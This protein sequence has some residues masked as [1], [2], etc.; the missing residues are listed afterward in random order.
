MK[1]ALLT[2][3]LLFSFLAAFAQP[4]SWNITGIG[5]GGAFFAPS[6]NPANN[7]EYYVASDM[8][9]L[10]HTTD[11]GQSY[12]QVHFLQFQGGHSSTVRFTSTA[13][14]LYGIS[15][16]NDIGTPVKSTDNG[17]TW[18]T[19]AGNPD[20]NS[21]VYTIDV[22]YNNPLRVVI[23]FYGE[24]YFSN[25][26]GNTFT[27]FHTCLNNGAGNVVGGVFFDGNNIYVGTNDGVLVSTNAG[28]SWSTASISGLGNG[29]QIFSFAAGKVGNVTRFFCLTSLA[30]N[31]YVGVVGSDYWGFMAGVYSCDYGS[32]NWVP[33]M[34]GLAV[35]TDF[36]MF[37][38]M[39]GN[40]INTVYLGGS[41]SN[42][43]PSI[44][45]TTNA[46]GL[47]SETFIT[48][49]NQ[50]IITGWSGTGGDRGWGF[51]EC[52]FGM[53]VAPNNSGTVIFG[54]FGFVH[55]TSNGGTTWQQAYVNTANQ[56]PAN[57]NTPPNQ[58]YN[59]IGLE[60]TSCWQVHFINSSNIFSCYTDIRGIRSTDAGN[61]WSFNYTGS[62]ANTMYR[63]AQGGNGTL[64]VA[65][66]NIHDMYE[67]TR[68]QDAILDGTDANG[69][70]LYSN[71]NGQTWT[72][73][74]NFNHPVVWIALDPNNPNRAY[75]SV[76]HYNGGN[77]TGGIYICNDLQN[78][79]SSTWTLLADPPRTEKHPFSLVVLNDGKLVATFSGRRNSSGT[80]T[81]S[82]GCYIYDPAGNSWTDVSDPGMDYYTKDI[83]VDPND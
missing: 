54:D 40:D 62:T 76:I 23:S 82:S 43:Y 5:G 34:N 74:H 58:S 31:V 14:L 18:N 45:K 21:D 77:G 70:I 57:A 13:N 12:S 19:L 73:L 56:H 65:T 36:P 69:K 46:G 2:S 35:G 6:I 44:K 32:G 8:S 30:G 29:E 81:A 24:I 9:A 39:A 60:N 63:M 20:P 16:I 27:L 25:D 79:S 1:K 37:V 28:T 51:G 42:S 64:Y 83:V 78:L 71:N 10:Y 48:A 75:A 59:S 4:A 38:G 61:S 15:Y 47:W 3:L 22:D 80:F 11:F 50:N 41:N 68:L 49:S 66:S 67:T 7:S 52:P 55:K 17:A 72:L 26:G 33:K 53:A